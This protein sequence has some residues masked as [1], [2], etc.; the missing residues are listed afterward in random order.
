MLWAA[1]EIRTLSL[2]NWLI[3]TGIAGFRLPFPFSQIELGGHR[4]LRD[5]IP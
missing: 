4:E 2:L 5:S 1:K 3:G